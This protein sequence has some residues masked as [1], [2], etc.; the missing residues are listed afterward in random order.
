MTLLRSGSHPKPFQCDIKP[1][2][3]SAVALINSNEGSTQFL[4]EE[5]Y[6][7]F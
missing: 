7:E 4:A 5:S 1:R 6:E 3:A 2:S